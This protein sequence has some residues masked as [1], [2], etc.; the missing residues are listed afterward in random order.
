MHIV[1]SPDAEFDDS[2][3][4][5]APQWGSAVDSGGPE[6]RSIMALSLGIRLAICAQ[7]MNSTTVSHF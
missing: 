1:R 5:L 4:L 2:I 6:T 3:A 7:T